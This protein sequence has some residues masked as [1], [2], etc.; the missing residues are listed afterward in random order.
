M[1][2]VM[3]ETN[4]KPYRVSEELNIK[5]LYL[6][7]VSQTAKL[8]NIGEKTLRGLPIRYP[9]GDFYLYKGE[10]TLMFKKNKF[11]AFLDKQRRI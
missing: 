1:H 9:K 11:E 5:D 2:E 10:K 3:E 8:F 6:L 7:N 4:Q